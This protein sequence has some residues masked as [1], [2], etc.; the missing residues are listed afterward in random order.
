MRGRSGRAV[1]HRARRH[2]SR[3]TL[4][5]R[6]GAAGQAAGRWGRENGR[7]RCAPRWRRRRRAGSSSRRRSRA[8]SGR[9]GALSE[10]EDAR[11]VVR[12]GH[13]DLAAVTP[14]S[15]FGEGGVLNAPRR[16]ET[17]R[18]TTRPLH[19]FA[20]E[21]GR[22]SLCM[23]LCRHLEMPRGTTRPRRRAPRDD[24]RD[25]GGRT[26]VA[27]ARRLRVVVKT[28]DP[29]P[30]HAII[31]PQAAG[32]AAAARWRGTVVRDRPL[33]AGPTAA[34]ALVTQRAR[35]PSPS[36]HDRRDS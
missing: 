2:P 25:A 27:A 28:R 3:R 20:M 36:L 33:V 10:E 19:L 12:V 23:R 17:P 29:L 13:G 24:A 26:A 6:R 22:R 4:P 30:R 1:P 34:L 8:L 32:R 14:L 31:I 5:T 18:G 15:G 9:F 21:E 35:A 16:L 7:T 11:A